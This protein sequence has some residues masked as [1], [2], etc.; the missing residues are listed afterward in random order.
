MERLV[1]DC[2]LLYVCFRVAVVVIAM[3]T[4]ADQAAAEKAATDKRT[5]DEAAASAVAMANWPIGGYTMLIPLLIISMYAVLVFRVD[6]STMS[7]VHDS[8][9]NYQ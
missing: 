7:L 9:V 5:A 2:S 3:S 1:R 4:D 6:N 8:I